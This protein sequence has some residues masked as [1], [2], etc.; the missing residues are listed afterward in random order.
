MKRINVFLI[1]VLFA[2]SCTTTKTMKNYKTQNA[3]E[4]QII[5]AVLQLKEA[6]NSHNLE[7]K[8]QVEKIV[9]TYSPGASIQTGVEGNL[10][11]GIIVNREEFR[12]ICMGKTAYRKY[13]IIWEFHE[14]IDLRLEKD[15]AK[16][17][18][19][20]RFDA[21]VPFI[22]G[23]GRHVYG[24]EVG[25]YYLNLIKEDGNWLINKHRWET[26]DTNNPKFKEYKKIKK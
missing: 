9:A 25:I 2:F 11:Q 1:F 13:K 22:T 24:W 16:V 3:T 4:R 6:Y 26:T 21:T 8:Q 19:G 18:F 15:K 5:D 20:Y 23:S 7:W 10:Y 17:S 14:P 12:A